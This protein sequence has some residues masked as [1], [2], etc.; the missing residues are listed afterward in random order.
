MRTNDIHNLED[1][2]R[3][4]V[5]ASVAETMAEDIRRGDALLDGFPSPELSA[6]AAA[7]LRRRLDTLRPQ[8]RRQTLGSIWAGIAAGAAAAAMVVWGISF[9]QTPSAPTERAPVAQ[10]QRPAVQEPEPVVQDRSELPG[11]TLNLWEDTYPAESDAAFSEIKSEL[12][13]IAA[14]IETLGIMDTAFP[15]ERLFNGETA[16]QSETKIELTDFWKG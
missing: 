6:Q 13:N 7:E 9:M 3:R 15:D 5:D 8:S 12:D 11:F 16:S 1:L 10:V 4:F 2:L 14:W